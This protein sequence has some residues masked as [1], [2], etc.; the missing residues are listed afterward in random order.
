MI[1]SSSLNDTNMSIIKYP[2]ITDKAPVQ[3][4]FAYGN[5]MVNG[6]APRIEIQI[7][8]FLPKRSP[9]SPPI[10]VPAATEAK[11]TNK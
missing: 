7:I 10:N 5:S 2:I 9:K 11:K 3:N 8:Y 6:A 4:K 1:N